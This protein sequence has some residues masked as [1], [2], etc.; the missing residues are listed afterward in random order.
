MADTF[1]S[2]GR[3]DADTTQHDLYTATTAAIIEV[4]ICNQDSSAR[5]VDLTHAPLGAADATSHYLLK[6]FSIPANDAW[7][8]PRPIKMVATDKLR[9]KAGTASVISFRYHGIET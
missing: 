3:L 6:G 7:F 8:C 9:V 5:T 2:G 4:V 1:V